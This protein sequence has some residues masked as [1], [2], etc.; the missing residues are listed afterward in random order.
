M[1]GALGSQGPAG[2]WGENAGTP[3][4][5]PSGYLLAAL[6]LLVVAPPALAGWIVGAAVVGLGWVSRGRLSAAGAV[7]GA[8]ALSVIVPA[9]AAA[10]SAGS[11]AKAER[12]GAAHLQGPTLAQL[13]RLTLDQPSGD[14]VLEE[15]ELGPD[16]AGGFDEVHQHQDGE[17][18]VAG[19]RSWP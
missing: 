3:A 15:L 10:A 2:R 14:Q 11:S 17:L 4:L 9:A 8:L 18:T 6:T 7:T 13:V 12:R 16:V 19:G 1:T 5:L